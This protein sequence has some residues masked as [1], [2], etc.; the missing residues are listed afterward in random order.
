MLG[1][2]DIAVRLVGVGRSDQCRVISEQWERG[3][4]GGEEVA[5]WD[6]EITELAG[7][8]QSAATEGARSVDS[9]W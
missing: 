5:I 6:V 4:D 3:C 8:M 9:A 2:E 7:R 1:V